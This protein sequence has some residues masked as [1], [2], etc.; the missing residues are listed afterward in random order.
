MGCCGSRGREKE[1]GAHTHEPNHEPNHERHH[2]PPKLI[3][4]E[5]SNKESRYRD[6]VELIRKK[7]LEVKANLEENNAAPPLF[8][9]FSTSHHTHLNP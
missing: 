8:Y 4:S 3:R 9:S 6:K 2:P 7:Q 5:M 1:P